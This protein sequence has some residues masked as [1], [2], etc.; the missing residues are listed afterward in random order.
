MVRKFNFSNR[1]FLLSCSIITLLF[2]GITLAYVLSGQDWKYQTSPMGEN[3]VVCENTN[4]VTGELAAIQSAAT[5]WNVDKCK[6]NFTYGSSSCNAAP[7]YDNVNQIRWGTTGGSLATTTWWYNTTTGDILEADCEFDDAYTWSTATPT[8][9]G[10]YDIETVMLHEF[11]HYLSLDH[12]TPPAIMQPTVS[13]GTQRRAL[14]S[15]DRNGCRVIYGKSCST[16]GFSH[17]V[18]SPKPGQAIVDFGLLF[19]PLLLILVVRMIS[20]KRRTK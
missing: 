18:I 1:T 9:V 11:G 8:P 7:V 20:Y 13:S 3:Y 14:T 10:A 12:S 5:T 16:L 17:G 2:V 6:F 19:S 15:D 4:D